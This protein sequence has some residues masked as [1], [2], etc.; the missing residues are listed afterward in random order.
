M[1]GKS[2]TR[3]NTVEIHNSTKHYNMKTLLKMI[4]MIALTGSLMATEFAAPVDQEV[5]SANGKFI[6][7]VS[8]KEGHHEVIGEFPSK[9]G[10]KFSHRVA[11]QSFF[12]T[13]DGESAA[14]VEWASCQED[15]LDQPAVV[16]YQREGARRTF[17]YRE[18]SLPRKRHEKE[19]GPIGDFWRIWRGDVSLNGNLLTIHGEGRKP[20]VIDLQAAKLMTLHKGS[21][22]TDTQTT[23]AAPEKKAPMIEQSDDTLRFYL[24]KSELVVTGSIQTEPAG[25]IDKKGFIAYL[26]QFKVED[27]LKGD[28]AFKG[29]EIWVGIDRYEWGGQDKH[30]LIKIGG[31]CLLFLKSSPPNA[32]T[33][34]TSDAW[35][36]IQHSTASLSR[37]L[38]RV[39]GETAANPDTTK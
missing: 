16:I 19:V 11:Y 29:K 17:S 39:L 33:W 22:A 38:K 31:E 35:F 18:L 21:S 5:K 28:A 32:P 26:C 37:S 24:S 14:V 10:W 8:A 36:G 4:S 7:R 9:K 20:S 25:T 27:V 1:V 23:I 15:E 6:L 2:P 12:V 13:D 3:C 34:M 30:P